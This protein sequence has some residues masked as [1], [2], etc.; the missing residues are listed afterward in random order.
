MM[1]CWMLF[2]DILFL[3][4]YTGHFIASKS[5]LALKYFLFKLD[6]QIAQ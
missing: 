1:G 5:F 2:F 4:K 3:I 6:H